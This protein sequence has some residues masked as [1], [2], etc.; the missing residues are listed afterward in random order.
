MTNAVS[1][2]KRGPIVAS[3]IIAAFV[4]ILAQ[5]LLNIALPSIMKD[6]NVSEN[7]AQWLITGYMLVNGVLIPISAYMIER[8][9]TRSLFIV[10][11]SL[12][13]IGTIV[14]ALAHSFPILLTGRLIQA[15]GAGILMPLMSIVFLT[16]F[17]VAERGKAMGMMG[18]AMIFAPAVGPTLSGW[19]VEHYS[20]RVLFYILLPIILF[21]LFYGAYAMKNVT[22]NA[23]SKLDYLAVVLSTLGFGGIL[24]GFS[25]AGTDGW[26]NN[27]VITSLV[28]GVVSL[29]L[30][31]WRELVVEKPILELRVFKFSMYSLTTVINVIVTM[32]MYSG[33]IL[34]P[35]YLQ[36]IRGFTPVESGL[37]LLPGA[38]LMGIMSPITG[39]IFDKIGARWLAVVGLAIT[40]GTTYMLSDLASDTTYTA[41]ITIYSFRMFG[42]SLLMMPIQ[43]AG[44]NQLPQRLNA[45]GSAMQQ[46]LRNVAGALGAALLVTIMTN[47]TKDVVKELIVSTGTN[48][49]DEKAML[50]LQ[51]QAMIEGINHAFVVATWFAVAALVLAFFIKKVKPH[52]E[53]KVETAKNDDKVKA[54][55]QAASRG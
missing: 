32:A 6:L 48:P 18:L 35:L 34:L 4:A 46:T 52:E 12:F 36:N 14:S 53:K 11:V 13:T 29:I 47:K 51:A 20:W 27:T 16:I 42:M 7:T 43:T 19:I 44:M 30:F 49:Q 21:A 41:L 55:T 50:P 28:I 45:H 23:K 1:N 25:D 9:T 40:V 26:N 3:L 5:T 17:P 2:L 24:Y 10:A 37:L 39:I 22:R 31:V 54:Q 8:F 15:A 38:I 33:M